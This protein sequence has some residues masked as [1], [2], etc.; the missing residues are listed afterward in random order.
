MQNDILQNIV[1]SGDKI[2]QRDICGHP[3]MRNVFFL[4]LGIKDEDRKEQ[5]CP[6]KCTTYLCLSRVL[7]FMRMDAYLGSDICCCCRCCT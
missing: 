6:I 2:V 3:G 1:R 4:L 5:P 7:H